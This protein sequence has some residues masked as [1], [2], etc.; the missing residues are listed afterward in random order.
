MVDLFLPRSLEPTGQGEKLPG[1]V[2]ASQVL[3]SPP[4]P[5]PALGWSVF[6]PQAAGRT[7]EP[8]Q[9]Q[10]A[11]AAGLLPG[12]PTACCEDL[13]VPPCCARPR[14]QVCNLTLFFPLVGSLERW[15]HVF[16][17]NQMPY[18][19]CPSRLALSFLSHWAPCDF[20]IPFKN[21][22]RER[23]FFSARCHVVEAAERGPA[24]NV[25]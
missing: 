24:R 1:R 8:G 9:R 4:L 12:C 13:G 7:A 25:P 6:S 17:S 14:P 11:P 10:H 23:F 20:K 3:L 19:K 22:E 5:I 2:G 21:I 16:Y 18:L 15:W